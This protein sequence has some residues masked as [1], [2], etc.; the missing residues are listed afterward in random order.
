MK[1]KFSLICTFLLLALLACGDN[2]EPAEAQ[3]DDSQTSVE[4]TTGPAL[5]GIDHW[6]AITDSIGVEMGD[7][8]LVFGQ[9]VDAQFLPDG[10]IAVADM[11]KNKISIFTAEGEFVTAVGR[12][13][14]GPG[15]YLMLS[16][17]EVTEDGGF[18]VPDVMGGKL[19]FYDSEYSFTDA[20]TG[21][22][23]TP[24]MMI[25]SV[26]GGFVGLKPEFEQGEDEMHMGMGIYLWT[27]SAAADVEYARNMILFDMNDL[28]ATVK[29]MVF[30][31][32]DRNDNV[33]SAPYSTEEYIITSQ[34][35]DGEQRWQIVEDFPRVKKS[36]EEIAEEQELIRSR[37]VAAGT[38]AEMADLF[39]IEEYKVFVG[40]LEV[41]NMN[42]LWVLSSV[43]DTAVYR[44]YDCETGE[45]LFTAA[46]RADEAHED[47]VPSISDYGITGLDAY[48]D[49]WSRVYIIQP[50]DPALFE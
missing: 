17:F 6:L 11:Q 5:P 31:D 4:G 7:S 9:I 47:M 45:F 36:D 38:P 2:T 18:I 46:L 25:S 20:M 30:F 12:K 43:Y 35:P 21:F 13:G 41:D 48:S 26:D 27:D 32:T 34:S 40:Q 19:N 37:M 33:L 49:E 14:S 22:F 28:A 3:T 23:P 10:N 39:Q 16:T 50:E 29:T 15:E 8:N 42:R 44:I 1:K 24:P